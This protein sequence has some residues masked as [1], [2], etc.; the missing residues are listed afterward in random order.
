MIATIADEY[1]EGSRG[2][3]LQAHMLM[4]P[5]LQAGKALRI[6]TWS[7]VEWVQKLA[8]ALSVSKL[9][10]VALSWIILKICSGVTYQQM[11]CILLRICYLHAVRSL[12]VT[13]F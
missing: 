5:L 10:P 8:G 9:L 12:D 11:G 6:C 2:L 1:L 7:R 13:G 4:C 3:V